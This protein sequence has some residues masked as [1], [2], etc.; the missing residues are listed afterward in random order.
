MIY[1]LPESNDALTQGDVLDS[2]PIFGLDAD[3]M[4]ADLNAPPASWTERVTV[5]RVVLEKLIADG[6]RVCQLLPPYREHMAQHFAVTYMRIG[7][8]IPYD[9]IP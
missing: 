4:G 9:T 5:P 2:C 7:L 3:S 6:K 8:P 1:G